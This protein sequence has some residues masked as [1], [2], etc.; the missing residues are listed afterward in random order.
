MKKSVE[1]P[2][3]K[4]V[5][6]KN[7]QALILHKNTRLQLLPQTSRVI[8]RIHLPDTAFNKELNARREQPQELFS[9]QS[10]EVHE[11]TMSIESKTHFNCYKKLLCEEL[12]SKDRQTVGF[13]AAGLSKRLI[14]SE[15]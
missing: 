3:G 9:P 4:N 15:Y 11:G 2:N 12:L 5:L 1:K 13:T 14:A 7:S 8:K 6:E 10:S